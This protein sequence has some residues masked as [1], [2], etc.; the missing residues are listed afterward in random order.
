[1]DTCSAWFKVSDEE[2]VARR[3]PQLFQ[4]GLCLHRLPTG[5]G[6]RGGAA[7][8]GVSHLNTG[9]KVHVLPRTFLVSPRTYLNRKIIEVHN[10]YRWFG[11]WKKHHFPYR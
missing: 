5:K 3:F 4:T 10:L 1:M 11:G 8:P 9:D 2:Q 6:V 7:N